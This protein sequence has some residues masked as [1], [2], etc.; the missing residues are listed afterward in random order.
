MKAVLVVPLL[1]GVYAACR[2]QH[3]ESFVVFTNSNKASVMR[4]RMNQI[5]DNDV[6]STTT[7]TAEI[8]TVL[9]NQILQVAIDASKQAGEIILGHAGG[10]EVTERKANS[11]D[12]LTWIDPLCEKV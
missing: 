1:I 4:R 10:A 6:V 11:R 9:L 7:S 5:N 8:T 2:I 3:C 12:L